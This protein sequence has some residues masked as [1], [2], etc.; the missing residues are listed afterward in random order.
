MVTLKEMTL[1]Q[2][3]DFYV[4]HPSP[5]L[6][7]RKDKETMI[8]ELCDPIKAEWIEIKS[9]TLEQY[10]TMVQTFIHEGYNKAISNLVDK[11]T[12]LDTGQDILLKGKDISDEDLKEILK[13]TNQGWAEFKQEQKLN[14]LRIP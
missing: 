13:V 4:K 11:S 3:T 9:L 12:P 1:D 2:L 6:R 10:K 14:R 5:D 7:E 8:R